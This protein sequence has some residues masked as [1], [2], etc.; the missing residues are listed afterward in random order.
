MPRTYRYLPA[1]ALLL[2][3]PHRTA[4]A[5]AVTPEVALGVAAPTGRL[6]THRSVG[7]LVRA[8]VLLGG[9]HRIVRLR[10]DVEGA[11]FPGDPP[12]ALPDSWYGD[13]RVMSG[14]VSLVVGQRGDDQAIYGLVGVGVQS[15]RVPGAPNPY[16][17]VAGLRLGAGA[18]TVVGGLRL[19]LEVTPHFILSD[20]A[21]GR[22]FAA[23]TYWPVSVSI[24]F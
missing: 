15:M 16:G 13:L 1:A 19:G 21:T 4:A 6:G 24:A 14:L 9:A 8:G 18:R 11:W 20:F 12:P 5:Q 22:D 3:P 23:G 17:A 7:P 10:A 2:L